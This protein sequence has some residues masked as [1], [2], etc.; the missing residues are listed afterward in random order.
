LE[1]VRQRPRFLLVGAFVAALVAGMA[2]PSFAFLDKTRFVAH[3]GIAYFCF[4]HWVMKPYQEGAFAEGAPH[5]VSA[6]VKGGV[7]ML[8]AVH[9]VQVS[10]KIAHTSKDPLLQKLDGGLQ[11]M[12][13]AF[14]AEGEKLKSGQFDPKDLPSLTGLTTMIE[15]G[16]EAAGA[17]IKDVPIALPGN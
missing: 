8:F 3:L 15:G 12:T 6:I 9:E 14:K 4:H 16:A 13:N 17:K 2:S 7:A 1:V 10:E 11:N 5:R